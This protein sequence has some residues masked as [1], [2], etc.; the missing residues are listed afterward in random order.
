MMVLDNAI[1]ASPRT[2]ALQKKFE[3]MD[4]GSALIVDSIINDAMKLSVANLHK[5]DIMHV[6]GLNVLDILRH[7]KLLITR[8]AIEHLEGKLV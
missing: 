6:D 1:L 2:N 3:S 7:Q 5:I 4:I 8:A